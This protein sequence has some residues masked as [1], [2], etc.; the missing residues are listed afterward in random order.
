MAGLSGV[1]TG[2]HVGYLILVLAGGAPVNGLILPFALLA[3]LSQGRLWRRC[4]EV[5]YG[6]GLL[7]GSTALL[8]G[9]L[10]Y[11]FV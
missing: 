8:L 7:L 2:C 11:A 9:W 5:A 10:W 3:L 1:L 6:R 4:R